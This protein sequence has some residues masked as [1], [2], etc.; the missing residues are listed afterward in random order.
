MIARVREWV[1][2][3]RAAFLAMDV[4]ALI[5]DEKIT[6]FLKGGL[7]TVQNVNTHTD[8]RVNSMRVA[9]AL[10]AGAHV[11]AAQ[12]GLQIGPSEPA[13]VQPMPVEPPPSR[14]PEAAPAGA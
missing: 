9:N 7:V 10:L 6:V 4:T 8:Q 12:A 3:E 14:E 2:R 11:A 5:P 13:P 1:R